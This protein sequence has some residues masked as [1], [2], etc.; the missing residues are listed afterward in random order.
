MK[1]SI[2]RIKLGLKQQKIFMRRILNGNI[3]DNDDIRSCI[4]TMDD[5]MHDI[6]QAI[7]EASEQRALKSPETAIVKVNANFD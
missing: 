7:K 1:I 3:P 5:I 2:K 6:E 4:D